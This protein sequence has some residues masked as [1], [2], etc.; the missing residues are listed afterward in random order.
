MLLGVDEVLHVRDRRLVELLGPPLLD[1][2]RQVTVVV[3]KH[4]DV[5]T[6]RLPT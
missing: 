2:Q 1:H 4:D 3:G 5:A 6:G